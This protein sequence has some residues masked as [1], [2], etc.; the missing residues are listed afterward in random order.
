M[1]LAGSQ[2]SVT[3]LCPALVRTGMSAIGEDPAA[4]ARQALD[5][6]AR[7]RFL[8]T[9]SEWHEAVRERGRRLATGDAPQPPQPSRA[10]SADRGA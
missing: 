8:V 6:V 4:V 5:A 7:G 10:G 1:A 9:P 2:V 3:V